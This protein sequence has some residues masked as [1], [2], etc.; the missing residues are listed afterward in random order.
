MYFTVR[1]PQPQVLQLQIQPTVVG[2]AC[3][4]CV[5]P[6][7]VQTLKKK[8]FISYLMD[9]GTSYQFQFYAQNIRNPQCVD[10]EIGKDY[11]KSFFHDKWM[12]ALENIPP[13]ALKSLSILKQM[14]GC[15]FYIFLSLLLGFLLLLFKV[16]NE[17]TKQ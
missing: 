4:G 5:C 17:T 13:T 1:P 6:E 2:K 9:F 11:C 12:E 14:V 15:L 7:H 8:K 3:D 16:K 10:G